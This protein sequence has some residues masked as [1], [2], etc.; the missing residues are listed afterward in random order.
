M[1]IFKR[2]LSILAIILAVVFLIA[3]L[4]GIA[5][6]WIIHNRI[7]MVVNNVFDV[8]DR[9]LTASTAAI[10][11]VISFEGEMRSGIDE[12]QTKVAG[13]GSN[14]AD[15]PVLFQAIDELLD[16]KVSSSLNKI[17]QASTKLYTNLNQLQVALNALNSITFFSPQ[18]GLID[19]VNT[20]LNEFLAGVDQ[21]NQDLQAF[22]QQVNAAKEQAV[23]T[24]VETINKPLDRIDSRLDQSQERLTGLNSQLTQLQT[25]LDN[26]RQD[27]LRLLTIAAVVMTFVLLWL[28]YSQVAVIQLHTIRYRNAGTGKDLPE[29]ASVPAIA[30]PEAVQPAG[31]SPD[32]PVVGTQADEQTAQQSQPGEPQPE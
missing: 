22:V 21:L 32:V 24:I 4:A 18:G 5:G 14:V 31:D 9:V 8:A 19:E 28:A 3:S 23:D 10:G 30:S 11:E 17:D 1:I 27:L 15:N 25:D 2:V 16:G 13:L 6:T 20:F 29:Q 12:I 7:S 26:T